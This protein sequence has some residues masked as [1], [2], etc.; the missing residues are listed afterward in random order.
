MSGWQRLVA[1]EVVPGDCVRVGGEGGTEVTVTRVE[2]RFLD[3]SGMISLIED[4]PTR[5][6]KVPLPDDAEVEVVR[7]AAG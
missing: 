7:E 2:P 4:T 1:A 6:L 3:R 5:W